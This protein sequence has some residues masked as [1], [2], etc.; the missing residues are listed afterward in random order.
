MFFSFFYFFFALSVL[1]SHVV[2]SYFIGGGGFVK[3][4]RARI[5]RV[6]LSLLRDV[7]ETRRAKG[8]TTRYLF[9]NESDRV[10]GSVSDWTDLQVKLV[11][12]WGVL[13]FGY[14]ELR[15]RSRSILGRF[16]YILRL[17]SRDWKIARVPA[18][19]RD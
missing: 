12:L 6:A 14:S 10:P 8:K 17:E 15:L 9:V 4:G 2:V 16:L 3:L 19:L 18:E 5:A 11:T 13:P 1:F 7:D